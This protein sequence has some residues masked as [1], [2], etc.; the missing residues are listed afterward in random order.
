MTAFAAALNT[1]FADPNFGRDAVYRAGGSGPATPVRAILRAPDRI[2]TFNQGRFVADTFLID[3]RVSE[4]PNPEPGDT[5]AIGDVTYELRAD[6][7]RDADRLT[8]ACE[9]RPQ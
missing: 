9:A 5:L 2:T 1:L 4:V 7:V 3:L 8:W 6:P